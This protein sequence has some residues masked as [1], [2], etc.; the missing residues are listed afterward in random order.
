MPTHGTPTSP[1]P[2]T[3]CSAAAPYRQPSPPAPGTKSCTA[4]SPPPS[5]PS[6]RPTISTVSPTT[7]VTPPRPAKPSTASP[8]PPTR[9]APPFRSRSSSASPQS[10]PTIAPRKLATRLPTRIYALLHERN[11]LRTPA[12]AQALAPLTQAAPALNRLAHQTLQAI[13]DTSR[14]PEIAANLRALDDTL[15]AIVPALAALPAP[16]PQRKPVLAAARALIKD[17]KSLATALADAQ[18]RPD[19]AQ[20]L[21]VAALALIGTPDGPAAPGSLHALQSAIAH[22]MDTQR[23]ELRTFASQ[24]KA[25]ATNNAFPHLAWNAIKTI[26]P[27]TPAGQQIAAAQTRADTFRYDAEQRSRQANLAALAAID[28]FAP[29]LAPTTTQ[30]RDNQP[31]PATISLPTPSEL[32][33]MPI[34]DLD[35]EIPLYAAESQPAVAP[36]QSTPAPAPAADPLAPLAPSPAP[37]AASNLRTSLQAMREYYAASLDKIDRQGPSTDNTEYR[38]WPDQAFAAFKTA[39]YAMHDTQRDLTALLHGLDFLDYVRSATALQWHDYEEGAQQRQQRTPRISRYQQRRDTAD[40][41]SADTRSESLAKGLSRQSTEI[42]ANLTYTRIM[43]QDEAPGR[44]ARSLAPARLNLTNRITYL[45]GKITAYAARFA[46]VAELP[47]PLVPANPQLFGPATNQP[48]NAQAIAQASRERAALIR[49]TGV[50]A[51]IAHL[52]ALNRYNQTAKNPDRVFDPKTPGTYQDREYLIRTQRDRTTAILHDIRHIR[53]AILELRAGT[54]P[55]MEPPQALG[56]QFPLEDL[57]R[58]WKEWRDN[59]A[60]LQ[61]LNDIE[62]AI[63]NA[64]VHL[65]FHTQQLID[66]KPSIEQTVVDI[67]VAAKERPDLLPAFRDLPY[68]Q[69][70]ARNLDREFQH[71]DTANQLLYRHYTQGL[72]SADDLARDAAQ[73]GCSPLA[74]QLLK[75]FEI[76]NVCMNPEDGHTEAEVTYLRDRRRAAFTDLRDDLEAF[77]GLANKHAATL[78]PANPQPDVAAFQHDADTLLR[79]RTF[80]RLPYVNDNPRQGS[81]THLTGRG[82]DAVDQMATALY[83]TALNPADRRELASTVEAIKEVFDRREDDDRWDLGGVNSIAPEIQERDDERKEWTRIHHLATGAVHEL[84]PYTFEAGMFRLDANPHYDPY[85]AYN[86]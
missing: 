78:D 15:T 6:S 36:A 82:Q 68:L 2:S 13:A 77:V 76:I 9:P 59:D 5:T 29:E 72:R 50:S 7:R 56:S 39:R 74:I 61:V 33:D 16:E 27:D 42:L 48:F 34:F 65:E 47:Q 22:Q 58:Y 35:D 25:Y 79:R 4:A 46:N 73:R 40:Q 14:L 31:D 10:S 49:D 81:L 62:H 75:T 52:Y 21:T 23:A 32:D 44:I 70:A 63:A 20:P 38:G 18:K 3:T 53:S 66:G 67:V 71:L 45:E 12:R 69:E 24:L 41:R 55:I 86:A 37:S 54:V 19:Y 84:D 80:S 83:Q 1:R 60:N 43:H 57:K 26:G 8:P 11:A 28:A 64:P 30:E 85:Y 51:P 17:A